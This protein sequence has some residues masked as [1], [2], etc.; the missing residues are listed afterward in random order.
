MVHVMKIMIMMIQNILIVDGD[1]LCII[2]IYSLMMI[3]VIVFII[4]GY[5]NERKSK[6]HE[7]TKIMCR[8]SRK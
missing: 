1:D 3:I 8:M 6:C 2:T 4:I 5:V 7:S